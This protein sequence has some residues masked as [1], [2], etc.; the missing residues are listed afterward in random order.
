MNIKEMIDKYHQ[1]K[2]ELAYYRHIDFILYYDVTTDAP[3]KGKDFTNDV[4]SFISKKELDLTLN[5]EYISLINDLYSKKD[6]LDELDRFDIELEYK[7]MQKQLRVPREELEKHIDNLNECYLTWER[8]RETIDYKEFENNLE[9]LVTYYKKYTKWQETP[10]LK[11][12]DVLLDEMEEGYNEKMYDAFFK[13]LE[14][15]LLPFVKKVFKAKQ[16]YNPKLDSLKFDISK[17][18]EITKIIA[19]AMGY[20]SDYGCIRETIHPY[21]NWSNNKDVR[22]TTSYSEDLLFSNLY[23]IMHEIG[24]AL[25]QLQMDDKFNMRKSFDAVTCIT[26]ESQSRFY[27]NY[28]GRSRA[29]ISYLY[30]ILLKYYPEELNDI[31]EDDIY[32]YVNSVKPIFKRTEADELTYPFHIMIRYNVEKK[33]FHNEIE[34]KDIENTFNEYMFKYLGIT[35]KNKLEGCFQDSHWS[36]M[37]GYFPTYAVG[38]AYGSMFLEEMKKS[39]NVDEDLK[40]GNFKNINKWLKDNIHQFAS[41]RKNDEVVRYVCHKDFD[42]EIY[43]DYLIN[44]FSKIYNID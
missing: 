37:F 26:H 38:S 27:E 22:I 12:Y 33:L 3:K 14:D 6:E 29:F 19:D 18:K 4:L 11:G 13:K 16:R 32:Y 25:F 36:S 42:P 8:A 34:V 7:D 15:R 5:K 17:Q 40:H 41:L 2:K 31:T 30:P 23:S 39:V 9:E 44:K 35:P 28:L 10:L 20:N 21:T 43:I 1:Y 24:H